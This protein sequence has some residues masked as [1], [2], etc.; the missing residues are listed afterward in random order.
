E[1]IAFSIRATGTTGTAEFIL[2]IAPEGGD[3]TQAARTLSSIGELVVTPKKLS[4]GNYQWFFFVKNDTIGQ[5]RS[6]AYK[7]TVMGSEEPHI[8]ENNLAE[9]NTSSGNET[10]SS[11]VNGVGGFT[12][13]SLGEKT[14]FSWKLLPGEAVPLSFNK[15]AIHSIK[16]ITITA[17]DEL[18]PA[19]LVIS[20]RIATNTFP[21]VLHPYRSLILTPIPAWKNLSYLAEIQFI[22]PVSW[23]NERELLPENVGAF[24]YYNDTW[25]LHAT[26]YAGESGENYHYISQI[27]SNPDGTLPP[28]VLAG[29]PFIH[30]GGKASEV[31]PK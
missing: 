4:P 26:S 19:A 18:S 7:L 13:D 8:E 9:N 5:Q 28:V 11:C 2:M 12:S 30:Y 15:S 21:T 22:I 25:N 6:R 29:C 20:Q 31:F 16:K 10:S 23:I 1:T 17:I 27:Q 24:A 3:F 14:F